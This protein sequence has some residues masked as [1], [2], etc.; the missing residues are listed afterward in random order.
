MRPLLYC[1]YVTA[2]APTSQHDDGERAPIRERVVFRSSESRYTRC[3]HADRHVGRRVRRPGRTA[4][5]R[6]TSPLR[7]L[8]CC[9][10]VTAPAPA[11]QHD[12][13]ERAPSRE[14]V[15]PRS[16]PPTSSS[17]RRSSRRASRAPSWPHRRAP[18]DVAIAPASL[19][20]VRHRASSR[21]P[22]RRQRASAEP[23]ARRSLI[24][25]AN[26]VVGTP[27]VTSGVASAV[28]AA[29]PSADRRRHHVRFPA[30]RTSLRQLPRAST[31]TASEHRAASASFLDRR[32]L[33]VV[34]TPIVT[35]GAACAVL[36]APPS[37]D[38]R[39]YH[40]R[41]SAARTSPRQL[42]RANTTTTSERRAASTSIPDRAPP[43]S[44]SERR[45]PRRTQRAPS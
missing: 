45:S 37:A 30:A 38:R 17:A 23:R 26:L 6:P 1:S 27:I 32:R 33:L 44:L 15:V 9:S 5:R 16:A 28:L 20:L 34:G 10:Y 42:P 11:S 7:P 8:L 29:R 25:A 19:L 18:T 35:S 22:A 13:G 4:K 2:P 39:R 24:G 12:D 14:R 43:T 41:L 21:E 40:A 3:Q 36:A 31:T